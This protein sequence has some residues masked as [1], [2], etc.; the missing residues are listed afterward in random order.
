MTS[1]LVYGT[2]AHADSLR[3]LFS[4]ACRALGADIQL[5]LFG[6]GSLFQRLRT[7]RVAPPP[8]VVVWFGPYAAHTAAQAGLLQA[9]QPAALPE[10]V[11]HEAEWRWVAVNFQPFRVDGAPAVS[12]FDDLAAAPRLALPDPERSEV[13]MAIVL[14]VLDRARQSTGDVEQGWAWWQQRAQG[15]MVLTE[16]EL[17]A[18]RARAEGE[19]TH[20]LTLQAGSAAVDGL[21]PLPHVVSL[22]ANAREVDAARRLVDWLVSKDASPLSGSLSA[23][24]TSANGLQRLLDAAPA[25]DVDWATRQY[26]TARRRWAQSGFGPTVTAR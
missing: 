12:G 6:S 16:D 3:A 13:G 21:A 11:A 17:G 18:Q 19:A 22:A 9:Y 25:L 4:R 26:A 24:Q 7:R 10:R 23:W 20:A 15:G 1:L 8:D 14:A 2:D 5:E